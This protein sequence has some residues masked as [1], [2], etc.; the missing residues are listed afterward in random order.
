MSIW[1]WILAWFV[2]GIPIL[3]V[4]MTFVWAFSGENESRKNYFKSLII[5]FLIGLASIITLVLIGAA[6][7]II[8]YISNIYKE[9]ART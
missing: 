4:I 9:T 8:E 2:M 3:N 7:F 1:F 5:L 6:P